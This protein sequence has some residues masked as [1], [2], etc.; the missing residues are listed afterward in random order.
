M[1]FQLTFGFYKHIYLGNIVFL[2]LA[3]IIS[4]QFFWVPPPFIL[5]FALMFSFFL[6]YLL[7]EF[8]CFFLT[9]WVSYGDYYIFCFSLC[10]CHL[11]NHTLYCF[12]CPC[13]PLPIQCCVLSYSTILPFWAFLHPLIISIFAEDCRILPHPWCNTQMIKVP[14]PLGLFFLI[15]NLLASWQ[16]IG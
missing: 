6:F 14:T 5:A 16:W 3:V 12:C 11:S 2:F 13:F 7:L 10:L 15:L 9:L 8:Y 4:Y 1:K